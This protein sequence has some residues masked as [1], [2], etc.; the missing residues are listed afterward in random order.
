METRGDPF[1]Q[2]RTNAEQEVHHR[3][4]PHPFII[5]TVCLHYRSVRWIGIGYLTVVALIFPTEFLIVFCVILAVVIMHF[6]INLEPKK[7]TRRLP[8]ER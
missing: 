1:P 7:A 2:Y 5:S 4:H 6:N 8:Y 3:H